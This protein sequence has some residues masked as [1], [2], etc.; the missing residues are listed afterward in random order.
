MYYWSRAFVNERLKLAKF[1]SY[2]II[3]ATPSGRIS[4]DYI[5]D[6]LNRTGIGV[7]F[8]F[9]IPSDILTTD[10]LVARYAESGITSSNIRKWTKRRRK[11]LPHY[12]LSRYALR[13]SLEDVENWLKETSKP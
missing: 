11:P 1:Q 9:G 4:S 2:R 3:P 10:E 12:R 7:P 13:F 6:L 5:V 8:R